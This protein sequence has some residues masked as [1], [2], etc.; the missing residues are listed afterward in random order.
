MLLREVI[1]D[2]SSTEVLG[3]AI[4][5]F[6]CLHT[7]KHTHTHKTHTHTNTYTHIKVTHS[8]LVHIHLDK[9]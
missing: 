3:C 6:C 9:K 7:H 2:C 5:C 8:D 1:Y 4:Y